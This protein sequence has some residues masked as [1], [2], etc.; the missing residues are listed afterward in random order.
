MPFAR[1]RPEV[2][3]QSNW[4]W[5]DGQ[6]KNRHELKG[7]DAQIVASRESLGESWAGEE[8]AAVLGL[9]WGSHL[10]PFQSSQSRWLRRAGNSLTIAGEFLRTKFKEGVANETAKHLAVF[11]IA[12]SLNAVPKFYFQLATFI[13]NEKSLFYVFSRTPSLRSVCCGYKISSIS[14]MH[15][16]SCCIIYNVQYAIYMQ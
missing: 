11:F 3:V 7:V 9:L 4:H 5:Q 16:S 12:M 13:M 1:N 6:A 15:L 14:I 8:M 2:E 10:L